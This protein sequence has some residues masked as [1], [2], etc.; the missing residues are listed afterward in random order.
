MSSKTSKKRISSKPDCEDEPNKKRCHST[1]GDRNRTPRPPK[2]SARKKG[3]KTLTQIQFVPS[4]RTNVEDVDIEYEQSPVE[5][6]MSKRRKKTRK[7]V[8]SDTLTQMDF[9]LPAVID[10]ENDEIIEDELV[11]DLSTPPRTKSK[12]RVVREAPLA[13]AVHNRTAKRKA[14]EQLTFS[15][16]EYPLLNSPPQ[17]S[18]PAVP[19]QA[20]TPVTPSRPGPQI[21]RREIP[22]SQSPPDTPLSVRIRRSSREPSRS[23][24]R[25]RSLNVPTPIRATSKATNP[26]RQLEVADSLD[27]DNEGS[28][29]LA[30]SGVTSKPSRICYMPG[31][32]RVGTESQMTDGK[33][34]I[35]HTSSPTPS[36][37]VDGGDPGISRAT[38]IKSEAGEPNEDEGAGDLN[39]YS[40]LS[41][42]EPP[43][44]YAAMESRYDCGPQLS[45]EG[46][47]ERRL[48]SNTAIPDLG[49]PTVN[50]QVANGNNPCRLGRASSELSIS[51]FDDPSPH[52]ASSTEN[53]AAIPGSAPA[54]TPERATETL[55]PPLY[56]LTSPPRGPGTESQLDNAWREMSPAPQLSP[57]MIPS[58]QPSSPDPHRYAPISPPAL[59]T[60]PRRTNSFIVPPLPQQPAPIPPSQATT[61]DC[62]S[63]QASHPLPLHAGTKSPPQK[64]SS[65]VVRRWE[66]SPRRLSSPSLPTLSSSPVYTRKGGEVSCTGYG[67]GV[68]DGKRLTDSQLLPDSL[69]NASL[70][71]PPGWGTQ[72][73]LEEEEEE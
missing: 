60:S 30:Q 24:L 72:D 10:K 50:D 22:S 32:L 48:A 71:G 57:D 5:R 44:A 36:Q 12:S 9:L 63:P 31:H 62:S 41:G 59:P 13:R 45:E 68:W 7:S 73:S 1:P 37:H 19:R 33:G 35:E 15:N 66:D 28:P 21:C 65:P 39:E 55:P 64:L 56:Q 43:A 38:Q 51:D 49:T 6:Q 2:S 34:T 40:F 61:V 3:Q 52:E 70:I 16:N 11:H 67:S 25:E 27:G 58:S 23:P 18:N 69:M 17:Q 8:Q 46:H 47:E 29:I 53:V 20:S 26:P 42:V 54:S 14:M 4:S